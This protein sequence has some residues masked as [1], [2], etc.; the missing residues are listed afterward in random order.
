MKLK[1]QKK[2]KFNYKDQIIW[3][4][5]KLKKKTNTWLKKLVEEKAQ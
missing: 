4:Q 5:K 2:W 3:P 1:N